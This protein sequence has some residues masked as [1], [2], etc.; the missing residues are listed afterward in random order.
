MVFNSLALN[1]KITLIVRKKPVLSSNLE[2]A[3]LVF[4]EKRFAN[5]LPLA[6]SPQS[7][8][9]SSAWSRALRGIFKA[10]P[11]EKP[12]PADSRVRDHIRCPRLRTYCVSKNIS[13][14]WASVSDGLL[15]NTF[16][17]VR[18]R[19][20]ANQPASETRSSLE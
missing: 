10:R 7:F 4:S 3:M 12:L 15:K 6:L 19:S 13:P 5:L 2:E 14:K 9:L 18:L 11:L 17:K 20:M 1:A 16:A 8:D